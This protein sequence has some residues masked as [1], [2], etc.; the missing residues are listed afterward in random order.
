MDKHLQIAGRDITIAPVKVKDLPAFVRAITPLVRRISAVGHADIDWVD[1]MLH[2][3]DE[4]VTATAL[5]AGVEVAWLNEQ[6]PEVLVSLAIAVV[7]VNA[8]FFMQTLLPQLLGAAE[9]ITRIANV[10]TTQATGPNGGAAG[11][12][13]LSAVAT[14]TPL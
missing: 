14:A 2:H 8:G 13:D 4:V 3:A 5:G 11:W 9:R 6:T 1:V 7:E 10:Q 12:M